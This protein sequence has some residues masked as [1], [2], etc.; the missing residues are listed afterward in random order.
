MKLIDIRKSKGLSRKFVAEY[1]GIKRDT[2]TAKELGYRHFTVDDI[3]KL[4]ELYQIALEE[5]ED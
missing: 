4:A 3:R 2:L 5:I 1:L